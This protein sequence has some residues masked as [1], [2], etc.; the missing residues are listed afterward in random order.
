MFVRRASQLQTAFRSKGA[1]G[2]AEQVKALST[3]GP[4]AAFR[5]AVGV[6]PRGA[7]DTP[8]LP[9]G[10]NGRAPQWLHRP[11]KETARNG[12]AGG[13]YNVDV[14]RG[15]FAVQPLNTGELLD[16]LREPQLLSVAGPVS[17]G[18]TCVRNLRGGKGLFDSLE[19]ESLDVGLGGL[20]V[21][22]PT[23][24]SGGLTTEGEVFLGGD[25]TV[26]GGVSV[27]GDVYTQGSVYN[28][29][30]V[31]HSGPTILQGPVVL[32]GPDGEPVELELVPVTVVTDV[33]WDGNKLQK[34]FRIVYV[35]RAED[36]GD[37]EIIDSTTCEEEAEEEEEE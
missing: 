20:R 1:A 37:E 11:G 7:Y 2:H 13:L 32:P 28:A 15:S 10:E 17:L 19:T 34:T 4:T 21:S 18:D 12:N 6:S 14:P 31:Y 23:E 33:F 22:G 27:G 8:A 35:P 24:L 16:V 26:E 36:G 9:P 30:T 5:G 25:V 3:G 29:G